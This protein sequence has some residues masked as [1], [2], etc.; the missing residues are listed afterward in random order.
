MLSSNGGVPESQTALRFLTEADWQL[1][2]EKA[3]S[4]EVAAGDIVSKR[5]RRP[6]KS[7]RS[8]PERYVWNANEWSAFR[9]WF[10]S[11]L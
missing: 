4:T 11:G 10:G 7:I 5:A 3:Q 1:V 9:C 2:L 8:R 6:A